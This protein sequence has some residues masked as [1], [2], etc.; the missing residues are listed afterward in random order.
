VFLCHLRFKRPQPPFEGRP[1][2]PEPDASHPA[3]GDRDTLFLQFVA[4]PQ[5]PV[6]R[7]FTG[8]I[9]HCLF[10]DWVRPVLFIG[11]LPAD[12]RQGRF[13]AGLIQGL[14]PAETVPGIPHDF[15][16]L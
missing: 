4:C 5:P 2:V 7:L 3:G 16:G 11:F 10:N 15:T 12:F 9:N 13:P 6:C 8:E 1:V 14:E